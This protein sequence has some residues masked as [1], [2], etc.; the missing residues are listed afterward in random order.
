MGGLN[1]DDLADFADWLAVWREKLETCRLNV[2]VQAAARSGEQGEWVQA[3]ETAARLLNL[4]PLSEEALRRVMRLHY[5]AGDR[6]AALR[7]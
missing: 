7:V 4:D 3:I 2:L 6:P 5:L 1:F